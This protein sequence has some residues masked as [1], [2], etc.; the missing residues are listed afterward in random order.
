MKKYIRAM[1]DELKTKAPSLSKAARKSKT[2]YLSSP[3]PPPAPLPED[4][5]NQELSDDPLQR[6]RQLD[7]Q[8]QKDE[9]RQPS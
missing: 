9:E 7:F 5:N 3:P 4:L 8:A 6:V 2:N 1:L